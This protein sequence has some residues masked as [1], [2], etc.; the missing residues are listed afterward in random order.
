M[1]IHYLPDLGF[2][3]ES[4]EI[5]WGDKRDLVRQ[6]LTEEF[7]QDDGTIDNS[8][9]FDGDTSYNIIYRRD[10]YKNFKTT[11]NKDDCLTEL[12]VHQEVDVLVSGITLIFGKD[13]SE[14]T[15][16]FKKL[17]YNPTV[18][19]EGEFFFESLKMVIAT[20]QSMGGEGN[21]LDYFYAGKNV[22]H[23]IEEYNEI[24][25]GSV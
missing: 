24:I 11:Y 14:F 25:K 8:Q 22:S 4:K 7:Q 10:L 21:G 17:N 12:E 1:T 9:F 3:I 23:V 20:S 19:K 13:I 15:N 18:V 6:N 5:K 16:Q 2:K